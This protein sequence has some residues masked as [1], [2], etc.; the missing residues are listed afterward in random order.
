MKK[1]IITLIAFFIVFFSVPVPAAAATFI[2]GDDAKSIAYKDAGI[3]ES[4]VTQIDELA[5]YRSGY[6]NFYK[7]VFHTSAAKYVYTINAS[8]GEIA[9]SISFFYQSDP[10]AE[11]NM[12]AFISAEEALAIAV[13]DSGL[14]AASLKK[15]EIK[16]DNDKNVY[17]YE[18]ELK[19]IIGEKYEYEIDALTGDILDYEYKR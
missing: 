19:T 11:V 2:S 9:D 5:A 4:Q 8:T 14:P 3:E 16:L 7:F 18:V 1:W 13:S 12:S 10:R 6:E 15:Q 17:Y